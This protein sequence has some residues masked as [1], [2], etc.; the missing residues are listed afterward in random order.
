MYLMIFHAQLSMAQA[1]LSALCVLTERLKQ[2]FELK[3][4]GLHV[5]CFF[6]DE[7]KKHV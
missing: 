2:G 1:Q 3:F 7:L 4:N 6:N 5:S